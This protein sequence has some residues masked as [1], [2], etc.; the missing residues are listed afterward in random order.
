MSAG[1]RPIWGLP[2]DPQGL[3]R[4]FFNGRWSLEPG[5]AMGLQPEY[6]GQRRP[7]KRD[8]VISENAPS[9]ETLRL[10]E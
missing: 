5:F 9:F 3:G 7:E 6:P 8:S 1:I 10:S 2:G 4:R